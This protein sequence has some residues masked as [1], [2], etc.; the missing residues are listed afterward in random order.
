MGEAKVPSS[1]VPHDDRVDACVPYNLWWCPRFPVIKIGGLLD[2]DPDDKPW[3]QGLYDDIEEAGVIRNPIIIWNHHSMRG[4]KQ[5]EW[6]LRAGSNRMWCVEQLGWSTVPAV[7][8]TVHNELPPADSRINYTIYARDIESYFPDGGRIW[9]N[10][11]GFGLLRAKLPEVTYAEI[12]NR[13][14]R[15]TENH[16][17]NKIINPLLG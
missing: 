14:L 2:K 4:G 6:L 10:K 3:L 9:A 11:H 5:P 1:Q 7:V 15:K 8:S 17:R 13:I 16:Q 12:K